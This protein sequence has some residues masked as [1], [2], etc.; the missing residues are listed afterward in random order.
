MEERKAPPLVT[1][2]SLPD[3][4]SVRDRL[5]SRE[6]KWPPP[7]WPMFSCVTHETGSAFCADSKRG[8][9]EIL[10]YQVS[11]P[12]DGIYELEILSGRYG[13]DGGSSLTPVL[14]IRI[15]ARE[16]W[17]EDTIGK[18]VLDIHVRGQRL[19]PERGAVLRVILAMTFIISRIDRGLA[20]S[21]KRVLKTYR[22]GQ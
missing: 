15:A 21:L 6:I 12:E 17:F 9:G 14:G 2:S 1:M 20:P 7:G 4:D 10:K 22:L 11:E 16:D 8:E 3:Q 19:I 18:A 5:T 13:Q